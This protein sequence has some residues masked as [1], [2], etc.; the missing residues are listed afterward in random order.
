[1]AGVLGALA[2][3][4][5]RRLGWMKRDPGLGPGI[6]SLPLVLAVASTCNSGVPVVDAPSCLT[7]SDCDSPLVCAFGGNCH[8]V[9]KQS[10]DCPQG[11][12]CI[13]ISGGL[14]A[15]DPMPAGAGRS[16][17]GDASSDDAAGSA[18]YD[19]A[20]PDAASGQAVDGANQ[21]SSEVAD[22]QGGDAQ[23]GGCPNGYTQCGSICVDTQTDKANCGGCATACTISCAQGLCTY[24]TAIVAGGN[25]TCVLL[26]DETVRCW[27]TN[28]SAE[29]G[30]GTTSNASTP[31]AVPGVI[32]A[33]AITAGGA[34][35]CALVGGAIQCWG[36]NAFGQLGNANF[37]GQNATKPC[38]PDTTRTRTSRCVSGATAIV[39][40]DRHTC[41]LLPGG[42]VQCWGYNA[43]GELGNGTTMGSSA[44]VTVSGLSG[45]TAIEAGFVHTCALLSGDTVACWGSGIE[46]G[47]GT[48]NNS[49]TP[50]ALPNVSNAIALSTGG[51][52]CAVLRG[53]TVE[54]WPST[55][56]SPSTPT[57]VPNLN[58]AIAVSG[59]YHACALS[60]DGGVYCWGRNGSGQ[61]GNGT[62]TD[63]STPV[64]VSKLPMAIQVAVGYMHSCA[65]L[66]D[67]SVQCWGYN[68]D[69]ELG[70][71]TT[72]ASSTPVT[73]KW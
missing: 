53:G 70:K 58:T 63:S 14:S 40:G 37:G 7:N 41:A 49:L 57:S 33:T 18:S 36:S 23:D 43:D 38:L 73:V 55:S 35:T 66:S 56:G 46:L 34:H 47:L 59:W 69:G 72:V 60:S 13:P 4:G 2:Q 24:P 12:V 44:Q 62:T 11:Q 65:L 20:D 25:H 26:L 22:A 6:L 1:M 17:G 3:L 5:H 32:G 10:G 19:A 21:L 31:V 45:A 27:G 48:T 61:L 54:C 39:A 68:A 42:G 15:C 30:D 51:Y 16:G 71:P 9:C 64:A 29:L 67:H 28:A 8:V 50:A 52:P